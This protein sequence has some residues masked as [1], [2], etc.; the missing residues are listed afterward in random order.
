MKKIFSLICV[1]SALIFGAVFT[2]C[3]ADDNDF[4]AP[5][6]T[7]LYKS[8]SKSENSFTYSWGE[9]ENKKTVKFDVYINYATKEGSIKFNNETDETV[10]VYFFVSDNRKLSKITFAINGEEIPAI[11]VQEDVFP[12][13]EVVRTDILTGYKD[14]EGEFYGW[15]GSDNKL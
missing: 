1:L 7:W 3:D 13:L 12:Y 5:K 2:G 10:E 14:W 6:D 4:I 15:D 9:D 8:S 11:G